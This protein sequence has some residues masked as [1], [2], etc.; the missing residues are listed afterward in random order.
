VA[1]VLSHLPTASI[2]HFACH[3]EQ[4]LSNPM[5][6]ALIL[7]DGRLKVSDILR[8]PMHDASLAVLSACHTAMGDENLPDEVIHLASSLLFAGFPGVVATMW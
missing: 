4:N 7:H 5:D 2:V 8:T 3:G 6:S 1:T